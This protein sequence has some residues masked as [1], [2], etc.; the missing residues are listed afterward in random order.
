MPDAES[1]TPSD[2]AGPA[3]PTPDTAAAE[4]AAPFVRAFVAVAVGAAVREALAKVLETLKASRAR[5]AWVAP[6]NLHLSLAFLGNVPGTMLPLLGMALDEAAAPV[7]PF[8]FDAAGVGAFGSIRSPRVVWAGVRPCPALM[9]LQQRVAD[10]LAGIG[11]ELETREYRPHLTLGRVRAPHGRERLAAALQ[12]V[13]ETEFGA[14][15][16]GEIVLMRSELRPEGARY[17]PL[18]R[19]PCAGRG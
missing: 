7:A 14:V 11:V 17:T 3:S 18:H 12:A 1:R 2:A 4:T 9:I 15:R 5:V 8:S 19:A 10:G 16:V 13:R 6:G